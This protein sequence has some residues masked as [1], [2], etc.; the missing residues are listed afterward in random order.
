M[1][2]AYNVTNDFGLMTFKVKTK[3]VKNEY[4]LLFW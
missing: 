4:Q 1:T 3:A 2:F